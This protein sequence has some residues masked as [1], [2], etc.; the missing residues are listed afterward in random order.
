MTTPG[1]AEPSSA[2]R[3]GIDVYDRQIRV[4]LVMYG[5]VSLAV[6]INGVAQEFFHAV[7]GTGV[8]GL[9]KCLRQSEIAVDIISGA[10]AGGINGILLGCALAG[11]AVRDLESS[12]ALWRDRGG[13]AALLY[14]PGTVDPPSVFDGDGYYL[15][16]L[17]ACF[18]TL[19]ESRRGSHGGAES[20]R[21]VSPVPALDLFVTGTDYHG[22]TWTWSDALGEPVAVKDHRTVFRL[23]YRHDR[24]EEGNDFADHLALAKLARITSSF[25]GALAPVRVDAPEPGTRS[26]DKADRTDELLGRWGRLQKGEAYFIDGGVL[27]NKP[28]TQTIEQIYYR[29]AD[30]P[31]DRKLFF[32]EPDP[33]QGRGVASTVEAPDILGVLTRSLVTL[34]RYESIAGDLRDIDRHNERV[35]Q[36]EEFFS[37]R[38]WDTATAPSAFERQIYDAYRSRWLTDLVRAALAKRQGDDGFQPA[39][40]PAMGIPKDLVPLIDVEFSLRRLFHVT[41][42]I[43]DQLY[44]S[45]RTSGSAVEPPAKLSADA[46]AG[47]KLALFAFNRHVQL[48]KLAE[49]VVEDAIA[50][51]VRAGHLST[52][53]SDM[54]A[55]VHALLRSVLEVDATTASRLTSVPI[56]RDEYLTEA[57]ITEVR[58]QM[59]RRIAAVV[60]KDPTTSAREAP[61]TTLLSLETELAQ[62]VWTHLRAVRP[63]AAW[64]S[65]YERFADIDT[66]LRA[67]DLAVG[68][69]ERDRIEVIRV[70]SSDARLGFSRRDARRK[71][72]GDALGHFGGFFKASWRANDI[73]WGRL[74]ARCQLIRALLDRDQLAL[75]IASSREAIAKDIA[76]FAGP[77]ESVIDRLFPLADPGDRVRVQTWLDKLLADETSDEDREKALDEVADTFDGGLPDVLVRVA[78]SDIVAAG[79]EDVVRDARREARTWRAEEFAA[80]LELDKAQTDDPRKFAESCAGNPALF[81]KSYRV[82]DERL[83]RNI[84][85]RVLLGIFAHGALTLRDAVFGAADRRTTTGRLGRLAGR[86][87]A[88]TRRVVGWPLHIAYWYATVTRLRHVQIAGIL[89]SLLLL[90]IVGVLGRSVLGEQQDSGVWQVRWL[91]V[92]VF[93][94]IPGGIL[95]L[96]FF[97]NASLG[98]KVRWILVLGVAVVTGLAIAG[99]LSAGEYDGLVRWWKSADVRRHIFYLGVPLLGAAALLYLLLTSRTRKPPAVP[100]VEADARP[101]PVARAEAALDANISA[102][103]EA[104]AQLRRKADEL[105]TRQ[106]RLRDHKQVSRSAGPT[107]IR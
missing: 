34:P 12:A 15:K 76:A 26:K 88:F 13:I 90:G 64:Q 7:R 42:G 9:L 69:R 85:P 43:Y 80:P 60:A 50:D 101:P 27:D 5:G 65:D 57:A 20:A 53:S 94:L 21:I 44:P 99:G 45:P 78:Q 54:S 82:G 95:L 31:V 100:P 58:A 56:T 2:D 41:Y 10:S 81:N 23:R 38:P 32:V 19:L 22:Q 93:L 46:I 105:A 25:P 51:Y 74:D 59:R 61:S 62:R 14:R 104:E 47:M 30:A 28:F 11:G 49:R 92:W 52:A 89:M 107:R 40:V 18:K 73:L 91:N 48:M 87:L 1:S 6:Y 84:P 72:S 68:V 83:T 24:G 96:E 103:T 67:Y 97:L 35:A 55:E 86:P 102:V 79:V 63:L 3:A 98:G 106:K 33:E 4:A 66:R 8:Y 39:K 17:Q 37:K 36:A 70:S 77:I 75:L 29:T 16:E 71:V